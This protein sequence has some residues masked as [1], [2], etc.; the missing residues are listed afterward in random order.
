MLPR[1]STLEVDTI[2]NVVPGWG[3]KEKFYLGSLELPRRGFQ[4]HFLPR[5]GG[6]SGPDKVKP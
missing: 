3:Q 2:S 5:S 4:G 6:L 1:S